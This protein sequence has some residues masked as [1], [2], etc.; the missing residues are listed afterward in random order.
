VG[1]LLGV[2]SIVQAKFWSDVVA[3]MIE[4]GAK[5]YRILQVQE[6]DVAEILPRLGEEKEEDRYA[7]FLDLL[8]L[9]R[10]QPRT[11][12]SLK[13]LFR[14]REDGEALY[15]L[16]HRTVTDPLHYSILVQYTLEQMPRDTLPDL[17]LLISE[18]YPEFRDW[19]LDYGHTVH[20]PDR[21]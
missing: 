9:F 16:V 13:R 7:A 3:G 6:R 4:G 17:I 8:Q 1:D 15:Q 21:G 18:T 12:S 5:Y 20:L 11:R 19:I 14:S 2:P 10:D